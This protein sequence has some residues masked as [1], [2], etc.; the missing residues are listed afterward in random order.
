MKKVILT[1]AFVLAVT[2]IFAA[3]NRLKKLKNI[4]LITRVYDL[5]ELSNDKLRTDVELKLRLAG[6][7]IV[8]SRTDESSPLEDAE[9]L[10]KVTGLLI[11]ELD[12]YVFK[13]YVGL[14]QYGYWKRDLGDT[15]IPY[16]TSVIWERETFGLSPRDTENYLRGIV[17][18]YIDEFLIDYLEA[19]PK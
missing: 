4:F 7:N 11:P 16:Q 14:R 17:K 13:I 2:N 19:N 18:D 10:V 6:I 8:A 9:F 3:N 15:E 5:D 12:A 1:L